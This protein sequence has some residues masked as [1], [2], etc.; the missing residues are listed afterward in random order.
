MIRHNR[1]QDITKRLAVPESDLQI[2]VTEVTRLL[3]CVDN[4]SSGIPL[5][6]DLDPEQKHTYKEPKGKAK[7][8]VITLGE[9]V[10]RIAAHRI[11]YFETSPAQAKEIVKPS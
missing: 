2:K 10:I 1:L 11:V 5:S 9:R 4:G 8:F 7:W 3:V 6:F